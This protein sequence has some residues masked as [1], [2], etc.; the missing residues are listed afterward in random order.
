MISR[1]LEEIPEEL[2]RS[3]F[4]NGE[5][6]AWK[7][8]ECARVIEWLRS[9]GYAVLGMELW[10]PDGHNI[11]TGINIK[12]GPAIYCT[13]CDPLEKERW[14]DYVERSARSTIGSI[15]SFRWPEDSV[16]PSSPA[17]FN[18]TWASRRWFRQHDRDSFVQD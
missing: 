14:N 7:Q 17:Y 6:M 15:T 10:L 8:E 16:E 1:D 13:A 12:T 5:E 2:T 4:R 9:A 3:A 11:R 18:I